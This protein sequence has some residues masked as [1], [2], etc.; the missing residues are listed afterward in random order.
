MSSHQQAK[1][2]SAVPALDR[3]DLVL[4][5]LASS[6][7]P[8]HPSDLA[9]RTG[10]AKSTLYL[11]LASLEQRHW[12]EKKGGGYVIGIGLYVLGCAYVH[13]DNL[14][15]TFRAAAAEFVTEH[16]EVVQ[17]AVLQGCD[18]VYLAREDAHRP[19]RLVSDIG[20]RLPAHACALGKALLAQL[21][22]EDVLR[23]L[24]DELSAVTDRTITS[25]EVLC[26]ELADVRRTGLARDIEEV[27]TGL[28]CFSVYA[29]ETPMGR[30][31]AVST[32][33][34]TDRLDKKREKFIIQAIVRVAQQVRLR[35]A[36]GAGR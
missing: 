3:A 21:P 17:L 27:A 20:T 33:I 19:V 25:H 6:S 29:G 24:P 31:I 4:Q 34:P 5:L 8:L 36:L 15:S 22:D 28:I 35:T 23:L 13:L 14:Q 18:V 9:Q 12:I 32:S 7:K 1:L 30:Q 16:N 11:L 10:L 2:E 26:K